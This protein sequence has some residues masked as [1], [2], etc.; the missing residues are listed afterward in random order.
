MGARSCCIGTD[1]RLWGRFDGVLHDRTSVRII[2]AL[3]AREAKSSHFA[4]ALMAGYL[5]VA[6]LVAY[7][8]YQLAGALLS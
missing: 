8:V 4:V 1:C 2:G 3:L 6:W 5:V 7:G